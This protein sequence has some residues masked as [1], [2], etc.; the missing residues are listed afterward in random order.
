MPVV[1][2]SESPQFIVNEP[3]QKGKKEKKKRSKREVQKAKNRRTKTSYGVTYMD[4]KVNDKSLRLRNKNMDKEPALPQFIQEK[5]G[6][7]DQYNK[8]IRTINSVYKKCLEYGRIQT[9]N[10]SGLLTTLTEDSYR[11]ILQ[12]LKYN[13]KN[14][15]REYIS[16]NF[17]K[18]NQVKY[19]NEHGAKEPVRTN[20]LNLL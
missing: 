12:N 19:R 5:Q 16:L 8:Y 18:N 10:N 1:M 20:R 17:D 15:P 3:N 6:Q 14:F 4:N 7:K 13:S 9:F 2:T 11:K